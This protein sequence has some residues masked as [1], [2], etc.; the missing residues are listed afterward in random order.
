MGTDGDGDDEPKIVRSHSGLSAASMTSSGPDV[1]YPGLEPSMDEAEGQM[2]LKVGTLVY[3]APEQQFT[4]TYSS[5]ADMYA[6][7]IVLFEMFNYK[8]FNETDQKKH[9]AIMKL[10]QR[11]DEEPV[12]CSNPEAAEIIAHLLIRDPV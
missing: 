12:D 5:K 4:T 11:F 7:G 3:M 1:V 10:R 6:L 9:T 8:R 2:T